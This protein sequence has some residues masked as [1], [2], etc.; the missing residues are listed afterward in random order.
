MNRASSNIG[1]SSH[2][3]T[4]SGNL[5]RSI[6]HHD[7]I[8]SSDCKEFHDEITSPEPFVMYRNG[9]HNEAGAPQ[10]HSHISSTG[11]IKSRGQSITKAPNLNSIKDRPKYE[12]ESPDE[13]ALV[14]AAF[15]FGF[16][17]QARVPGSVRLQLP[18]DN[19][20]DFE[21]LHTLGFDSARK[22]MSV[23]VKDP[24]GK[25]RVFCKGA[26]TSVMSRLRSYSGE[27]A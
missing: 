2:G 7:N 20:A 22:R 26:D 27:L 17:L 10:I 1:F 11:S 16:K 25:I 14:K 9:L 21:L 15:N 24:G 4:N 5:N 3:S 18:N 8:Q 23:I 13:D 19:V 12:A 6:S